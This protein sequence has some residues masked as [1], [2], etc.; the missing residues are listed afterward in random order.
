MD[1]VIKE[2]LKITGLIQVSWD[3]AKTEK[4]EVS[5][6]LKSMKEFNLNEGLVITEDYAAEK[7]IGDK[8]IHFIPLW[9]WLLGNV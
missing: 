9:K 4:R 7:S 2:G 1:F 8:K 5:A 6:L 3:I